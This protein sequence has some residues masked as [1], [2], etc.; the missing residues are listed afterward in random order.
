MN[1]FEHK[2]LESQVLDTLVGSKE[3]WR[4]QF[5]RVLKDGDPYIIPC[6]PRMHMISGQCH[7][8]KGVKATARLNS[9]RLHEV[10]SCEQSQPIAVGTSNDKWF[11]AIGMPCYLFSSQWAVQ[12]FLNKHCDWW[13]FAGMPNCPP[14]YHVPEWLREQIGTQ[15]MIDALS[16]NQNRD[17][18]PSS[19]NVTT[20]RAP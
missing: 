2:G 11:L 20:T 13:F 15:E 3:Y 19:N 17:L 6:V 8:K 5:N 16:K 18:L 10:Y 4:E 14:D 12:I 7:F 9:G 1:P